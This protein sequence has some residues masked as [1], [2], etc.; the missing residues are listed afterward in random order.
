LQERAAADPDLVPDAKFT[1]RAKVDARDSAN[2]S[3]RAA[4]VQELNDQARAASG[5]LATNP[6]AYTPGTLARIADTYD[7]AGETEK[8][9]STRRLAVQ[10]SALGSFAQADVDKQRRMIDELPPG[11]LRNTARTIQVAQADAFARDAFTAGTALYKQ[12]GPAVP[13][14]NITGRIRQAREITQLRGIPVA[15]FT[16]VEVDG[17]R[18][19]LATGSDQDKQAVRS[20][21]A[22]VPDEMRPAIEPTV[23][24]SARQRHDAA[25]PS[26]H[27][28][29]A[30]ARRRA[31]AGRRHRT[32][33]EWRRDGG[34]STCGSRC[35]CRPPGRR[36]R[37][38]HGERRAHASRTSRRFGLHRSRS[39]ECLGRNGIP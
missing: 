19:A 30:A 2:E 17:L 25:E 28:P 9:A 22:G 21:L 16:A 35:P 10:E 39:A 15:P 1:V 8:A 20:L 12:V 13:I 5:S 7:A 29:I 31:A 27:A 26:Q 32:P 24:D 38:G 4:R 14:D 6:G 18:Q 34:Q 36:K 11:E 3:A 37:E 33:I 23:P